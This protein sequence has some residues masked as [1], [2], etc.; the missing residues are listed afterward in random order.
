MKR[1]SK[2]AVVGGHIYGGGLYTHQNAINKG[3]KV[4]QTEHFWTGTAI[5][6]CCSIAKEMNDCM[7][8]RMNA[9]YWWW[10]KEGD[11]ATFMSGST[12]LKNGYTMGQFARWVR[13]GKVRIATTYNPSSNIYVT[14]YRNN[15]IV[16]VAVNTGGSAVSKIPLPGA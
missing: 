13:P 5:G 10:M 1:T 11:G 6:T 7:N 14:A 8:S 3:K 12:P 4:W 2:I 15:G 9:Y 16:I